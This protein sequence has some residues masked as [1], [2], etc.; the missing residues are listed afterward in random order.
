[1]IPHHVAFKVFLDDRV[2]GHGIILN[3]AQNVV[4][5]GI[6]GFAEAVEGDTAVLG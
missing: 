5:I 2:I 3:A 4:I 6:E 1:M